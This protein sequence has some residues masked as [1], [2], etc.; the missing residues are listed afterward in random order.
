M[1]FLKIIRNK[2]TYYRTIVFTLFRLLYKYPEDIIF[3]FDWFKAII[4]KKEIEKIPWLTYKTI[5]WLKKNI[6]KD[7][8]VFEYGSGGS[9]LFFAERVKKIFSVEH[10]R[11]FYEYLSKII[12]ENKFNNITYILKEPEISKN[13]ENEFFKSSFSPE[14]KGLSFEKYVKII[15]DFPDNYFDL[16]LIDGRARVACMK[17][18][19]KKLKKKGIII[20]DN[21]ERK[22][23]KEGINRYLKNFFI[24]RYYG[25]GPNEIIPW[26]TTIFKRKEDL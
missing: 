17:Y 12:R 3:L 13:P 18:A 26:E 14:F 6:N 5:R 7:M 1:D 21:S 20:L 23:Y 16:I 4:R 15:E 24:K 11:N 10:N 19:V 2:Y 22:R 25:L 8:I 9:T